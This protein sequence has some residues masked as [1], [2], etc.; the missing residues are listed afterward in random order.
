MSAAH[1][2]KDCQRC[3]RGEAG[4]ALPAVEGEIAGLF[5]GIGG[6]GGLQRLA[7][8]GRAP[9]R[10]T[11]PCATLPEPVARAVAA[12]AVLALVLKASD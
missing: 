2:L 6:A 8:L 9:G 5:P 3:K 11:A 12:G 7:A 10:L 4:V 1:S